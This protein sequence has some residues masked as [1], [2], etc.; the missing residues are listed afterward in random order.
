MNTLNHLYLIA[1]IC[2]GLFAASCNEMLD[3]APLDRFENDPSFWDNA[4]NVEGITNSF[5]N[6]FIGYGNNGGYGLFYFKTIS[7]DQIGNPF[8]EWE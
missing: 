6:S 1:S 4:S 2:L 8:N 5:Y 3:K 7:D